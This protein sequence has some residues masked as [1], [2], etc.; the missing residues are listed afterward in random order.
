MKDMVDVG[1][2]EKSRK[3]HPVASFIS[4]GMAIPL[5][6]QSFIC[7]HVKSLAAEMSSIRVFA[8]WIIVS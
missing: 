5:L 3:K 6:P 4:Y 1:Q 8:S 7:W 2:M